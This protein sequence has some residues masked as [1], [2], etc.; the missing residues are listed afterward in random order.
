MALKEN[1]W[2]SQD[3]YYSRK[4]AKHAKKLLIFLNKV[5]DSTRDAILYEGFTEIQ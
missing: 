3:S 4:D 1:L 5:I 2:I